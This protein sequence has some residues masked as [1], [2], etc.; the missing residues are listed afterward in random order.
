LWSI[1]GKI[2]TQTTQMLGDRPV[3]VPLLSVRKSS[4]NKKQQ[5]R[6]GGGAGSQTVPARPSSN[7]V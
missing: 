2:L 5:K 6:G 3:P 1:G 7:D 4:K